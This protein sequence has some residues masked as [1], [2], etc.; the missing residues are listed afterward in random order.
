MSDSFATPQAVALP[1][2]SVHGVLQGRILEWVATPFFSGS[3]QPRDRT[4]V[5]CIA[6]GSVPAEPPGKPSPA[7][8]GR[9]PLA[10]ALGP[11][12]L[13]PQGGQGPS[14]IESHS[15]VA[16]TSGLPRSP[17]PSPRRA[18]SAEMTGTTRQA[19]AGAW[20]RVLTPT[21]STAALFS[22]VRENAASQGWEGLGIDPPGPA[23]SG[24]PSVTPHPQL[25]SP[26]SAPPSLTPAQRTP[27]CAPCR[28]TPNSGSGRHHF[29]SH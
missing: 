25:P 21:R 19:L 16:P 28:V 22:P 6:A 26:P 27:G 4:W 24:F 9:P 1:G 20:T 15:S 17:T 12:A 11:P 3:P 23:P 7:V 14:D 29:P 10:Q 18:L 13:Q 2:C 5:S 8:A